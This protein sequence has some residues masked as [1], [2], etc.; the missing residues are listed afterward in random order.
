M[1]VRD[2]AAMLRE[3]VVEKI[4][5]YKRFGQ[6]LTTDECSNKETRDH[7]LVL[8]YLMRSDIDAS[9]K[10]YTKGAWKVCRRRPQAP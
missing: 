8:L 4:L 3:K 9:V 2:K 7:L 5:E 10:R 6:D 1:V